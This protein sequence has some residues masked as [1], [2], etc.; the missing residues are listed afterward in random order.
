MYH[1]IMNNAAHA[2]MYYFMRADVSYNSKFT[3]ITPIFTLS[4][5]N[6][7]AETR[8]KASLLRALQQFHVHYSIIMWDIHPEEGENTHNVPS[9]PFY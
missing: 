4:G 2:C 1:Q 7:D 5:E 9:P 6:D 3:I 8:A